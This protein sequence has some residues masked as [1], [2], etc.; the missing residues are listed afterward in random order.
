MSAGTGWRQR[1]AA[2]IFGAADS[3]AANGTLERPEGQRWGRTCPHCGAPSV[4][5]S[6]QQITKLYSEQLRICQ[7]HLCGHVWV[8][9]L[10]SVRTLSP[11]AIPDPG[12][13]I[14]MSR[15]VKR[16]LVIA[17]MSQAEQQDLFPGETQA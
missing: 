14:P 9:G 7:N 15:H 1:L 4:I 8:D 12:I 16:E 17:T 11:S 6:S 5:R 13:H 3:P 10:E 2:R